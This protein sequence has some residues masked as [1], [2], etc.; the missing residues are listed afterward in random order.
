MFANLRNNLKK[1]IPNS[2]YEHEKTLCLQHTDQF[3][4]LEFLS[5]HKNK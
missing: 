3:V 2:I 1:I 4:V 5:E